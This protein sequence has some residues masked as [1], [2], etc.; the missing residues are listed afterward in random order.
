DWKTCPKDWGFDKPIQCG[1]VTV[2]VDYAKPD[3]RTIE[4]AVNRAKS[5]GSKD[6]RQGSLVYNPGGPGGSGMRCPARITD[7]NP[8]WAKTAKAYDFVGFDPRGVGHSAPISC[9]DP[10][11]FVKAPKADPVPDD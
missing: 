6:E 4:I 5:T 11:E 1:S 2:P 10:Q 3:G 8:L 9:M 7:E